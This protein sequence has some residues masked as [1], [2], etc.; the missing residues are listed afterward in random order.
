MLD[1]FSSQM[2]L[3]TYAANYCIATFCLYG[4]KTHFFEDRRSTLPVM[5]FSYSCVSNVIQGI[6]LLVVGQASYL[7]WEWVQMELL[8]IPLQT[9]IY[10]VVA[11][12]LPQACMMRMKK[13]YS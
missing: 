5:T 6:M 2:R 12:T 4:Y 7:S 3:G 13:R 10:S 9:A 11:F 8:V 1:L